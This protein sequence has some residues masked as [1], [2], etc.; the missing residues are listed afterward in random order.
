MLIYTA[1][2]R[3]SVMIGYSG[4]QLLS[5]DRVSAP[6]EERARAFASFFGYSGGYSFSCDRVVHHVVVASVPNWV[7]TDMLRTVRLDGNR[8]TLGTPPRQLGGIASTFELTWER[9]P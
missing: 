9:F 8:L 4:R 7:N 2:G 5:R 3:M 1:D 6:V